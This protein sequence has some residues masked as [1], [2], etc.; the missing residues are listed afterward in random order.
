MNIHKKFEEEKNHDSQ[1]I[2]ADRACQW[3]IVMYIYV[4]A[5]L[6]S[7]HSSLMTVM[8]VPLLLHSQAVDDRSAKKKKKKKLERLCKKM[9]S[10]PL[11]KRYVFYHIH[12]E[13]KKKYQYKSKVS[14]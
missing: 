13:V 8:C 7:E 12:M 1:N 10:F 4:F 2:E 3:A 11:F 5:V 6:N 14:W 9:V